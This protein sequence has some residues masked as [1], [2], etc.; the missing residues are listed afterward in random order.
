MPNLLFLFLLF[1]MYS[2][3]QSSVSIGQQIHRE[4]F[5]FVDDNDVF[6]TFQVYFQPNISYSYRKNKWNF[7]SALSTTGKNEHL[8]RENAN[9]SYGSHGGYS[10]TDTEIKSADVRFN[11]I[12]LRAGIHR[13]VGNP[14][15]LSVLFGLNAHLD[16]LLY[17]KTSNYTIG[18]YYY[19]SGYTPSSCNCPFTSP[20]SSSGSTSASEPF[21]VLDLNN[22]FFYGMFE[23]KPRFQRKSLFIEFQFALVA[24]KNPRLVNKIGGNYEKEDYSNSGLNGTYI[25]LSSEIGVSLGYTLSKKKE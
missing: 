4:S 6:K 23:I 14:E 9:T 19:Y 13:V 16:F 1:S 5:L 11:Y 12:G 17:S 10:T 15:G 25:N 3:A 22:N 24:F 18:N 20:S 2:S 8:K 7:F 21:E